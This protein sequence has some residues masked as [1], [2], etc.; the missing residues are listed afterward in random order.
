MIRT[1]I[2]LALAL[3][4][5]LFATQSC[6]DAGIEVPPPPPPSNGTI[7]TVSFFSEVYPIFSKTQYGCNGCHTGTGSIYWHGDASF[8]YANLVNTN[9]TNGPCAGDVR[10][11]PGDANASVLYRRLSGTTC[12]DR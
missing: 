7:D 11:V 8:T 12:G 3:A 6:Q 9:A 5:L 10:V 2:F 1:P 4:I